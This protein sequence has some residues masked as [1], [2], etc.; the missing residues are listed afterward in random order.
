MFGRQLQK[1]LS[2]PFDD[3]HRPLVVA[4]AC[5]RAMH[6]MHIAQNIHQEMPLD[7][8]GRLITAITF[9]FPIGRVRI[10]SAQWRE[11]A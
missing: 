3:R 4:D 11:I 2:V 6:K 8:V 5:W 10:L 7:A 1:I 9:S